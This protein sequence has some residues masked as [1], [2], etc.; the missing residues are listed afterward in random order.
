MTTKLALFGAAA[1]AAIGL[2]IAAPAGATTPTALTLNE[3]ITFGDGHAPPVGVFTA[4]GLPGCDS[5]TFGDRL[6]NF[7]FGGH[8]L[9]IDRTYSC[10]NGVDGFT[11]RMVL[12]NEPPNE[13]GIATGG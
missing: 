13:Q 5:G 4:D 7:N 11:A 6:N 1:M 2:L 10:E 9:V 8:T 3:S 12:H